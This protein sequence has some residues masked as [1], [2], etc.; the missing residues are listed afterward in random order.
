[1]DKKSN[2]KQK[3][4]KRKKVIAFSVQIV[5]VSDAKNFRLIHQ[6]TTQRTTNKVVTVKVIEK[7]VYSLAVREIY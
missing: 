5:V 4:R 1:M 6:T 3:K 7:Y 2:K